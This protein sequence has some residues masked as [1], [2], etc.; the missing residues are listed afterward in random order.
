MS[1][2]DDSDNEFKENM[3]KQE[4][5]ENQY[6]KKCFVCGKEFI[7]KG[8]EWYD[9]CNECKK[10]K[11]EEEKNKTFVINYISFMDFMKVHNF[12]D[13]HDS[14]KGDDY[15]NDT[16]IVR[17]YYGGLIDEN[18]FRDNSEWFEFGIYD[19]GSTN[20]FIKGLQMILSDK[21]INSYVNSFCVNN[22][23]GTLEV[24]LTN[25]KGDPYD[26]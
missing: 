21:I 22:E 2:S 5:Q 11:D 10:K 25:E 23:T 17:I 6:H 8:N 24:W 16:K 9:T 7:G 18:P 15:E 3:K 13:C 20:Q 19:F 14:N 1:F 26:D 4:E 12:R